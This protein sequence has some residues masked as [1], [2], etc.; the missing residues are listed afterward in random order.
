MLQQTQVTTVL[1]YYARFLAQWPTV[2]ALAAAARDE[3]LAAWQGLGYYRRAH[4]LHET[5]R[6]VV[7]RGGWPTE[8]AE[9]RALPGFGEY[10]AGALASIVG[11]E[12]VPAVDGNVERVLAR[13]LALEGDP[14]RGAAR[15]TLR[16]Y[17]ADLVPAE[18]PGEWNQAVMELGATVCGRQPRCGE[19]PVA[20][21]CAGLAGGT[22]AAYPQRVPRP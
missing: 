3:V 18:A 21:W 2:E 20:A 11:G 12:R 16:A 7:A 15:A 19:C 13:L 8:L 4:A 1:P 17:A 9:W 6:L 14:A 22:P 5:A 10:T